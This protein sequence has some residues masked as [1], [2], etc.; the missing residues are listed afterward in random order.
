MPKLVIGW[1]IWTEFF[2]SLPDQ[3]ISRVLSTC[4]AVNKANTVPDCRT[5]VM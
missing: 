4:G 1:R 5:S 3:R 2:E